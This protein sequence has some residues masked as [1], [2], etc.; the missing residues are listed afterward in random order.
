[1]IYSFINVKEQRQF[2]DKLMKLKLQD[3]KLAQVP[4]KAL[5]DVSNAFTWSCFCIKCKNKKF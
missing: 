5:E 2:T 4:S 1:M 3:P